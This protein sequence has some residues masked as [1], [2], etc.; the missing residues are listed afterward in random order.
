MKIGPHSGMSLQEIIASKIEEE[1]SNGVHYWGYSGVFCKP[2]P[3]Q[4]FCQESKKNE[5]KPKI[6]LLETKSSYDSKIGLIDEYSEN[7]MT[8]KKFKAPVQL[9]GAEFSFVAKNIRQIKNF[10]LD[11]FTV[12][13]GKN[14]GKKISEH[15]IFRV[16]K[17]FGKYTG[18][19]ESKELEA[20][21]ADLVEPY[22]IWLKEK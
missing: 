13:G 21:V 19:S 6:V 5:R 10:R 11:D 16:N 18:K 14:D 22:A 4:K 15:L 8:Y 3:T 7:N 1:K 12:V 2:I 17:C 20:Y 9:Q